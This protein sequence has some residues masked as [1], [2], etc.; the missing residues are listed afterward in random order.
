MI[1]LKT[2]SEGDEMTLEQAIVI[3]QD[4]INSLSHW[5]KPEAVSA[6]RVEVAQR[7][8]KLDPND[9]PYEVFRGANL[10]QWVASRGRT[11]A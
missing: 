4:Q 8:A 11:W 9:S 3:Q 2:L 7:N 10:G 6:L 5:V 1:T